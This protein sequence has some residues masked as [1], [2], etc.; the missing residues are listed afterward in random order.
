MLKIG[1]PTGTKITMRQYI[2]R[3]MRAAEA[4]IYDHEGCAAWRQGPCCVEVAARLRRAGS[5]R[6]PTI[7]TKAPRRSAGPRINA[8]SSLPDCRP[9]LTKKARVPVRGLRSNLEGAPCRTCTKHPQLNTSR[10][11]EQVA[12]ARRREHRQAAGVAGALKA[13]ALPIQSR[14]TAVPAFPSSRALQMAAGLT[15]NATATEQSVLWLKAREPA[16][17][18]G[19]QRHEQRNRR[20]GRR[21]GSTWLRS[22]R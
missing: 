14:A 17:M 8:A 4:C 3:S 10:S 2:G 1:T 7:V 12:A 6:A 19:F 20:P 11:D 22:L 16:Q 18:M 9:A 15:R 13:T 5:R 21:R